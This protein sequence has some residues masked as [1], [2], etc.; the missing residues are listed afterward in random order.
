MKKLLII[1]MLAMLTAAGCKS[2]S[3]RSDT[4]ATGDGDSARTGVEDT[5]GTRPGDEEITDSTIDRQAVKAPQSRRFDDVSGVAFNDV[6]FDYDSYDINEGEKAELNRVSSYLLKNSGVKILIEG[7]CDDRGTNEYNLALGDRRAK[8]VKDYLRST[9][10]SASRIET[11]SYGEE[12][13]ACT[14]QDEACWA[15]NRRAQFSVVR[16]LR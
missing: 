4:S 15:Q 1:A 7:H 5:T 3:V 9:G 16:E 11:I 13:P 6:H 14:S 12:K 2:S 10:V 8:S